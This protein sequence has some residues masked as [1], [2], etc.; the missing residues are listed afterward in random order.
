M[1]YFIHIPKT[2]GTSL[3]HCFLQLGEGAVLWHAPTIEFGSSLPKAPCD[4]LA[5]DSVRSH[6]KIYGGHFGLSEIL[7]YVT[8]EDLIVSVVREPIVRAF[9]LYNHIQVNDPSHPLHGVIKDRSIMEATQVNA[10]FASQVS[11]MQ[12]WQVSGHKD[13]RKAKAVITKN[14]VK[15]YSIDEVQ[16]L[17]TEVARYLGASDMPIVPTL[18]E[19]KDCDY[20]AKLGESEVRFIESLNAEDL[21][22]HHFMK[23]RAKDVVRATA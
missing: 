20:L 19:S 2:A 21:K 3:L 9:S 14:L 4:I 6:F 13:F 23:S 15:V 12:C 7:P 18:N 8:E 17:V 22:F 5:S 1:I 16:S 11:D 10:E